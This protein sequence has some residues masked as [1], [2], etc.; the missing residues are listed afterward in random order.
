MSSS[1]ETQTDPD[2]MVKVAPPTQKLI[3]IAP[4][5]LTQEPESFSKQFV[6]DVYD[7]IAPHFSH[8]RYK[9][10]PK[11]E[12]FVSN[13]PQG[14]F[15]MD[16]GCGNGKNLVNVPHVVR[17]GSDRSFPFC[18]IARDKADCEALQADIA[19]DIGKSFRVGIF[20]ATIAIAVIHHIPDVPG[21]IAALREI[22]RLLR[23]GGSALIYVWA[24]EQKK[25]TIGA[26]SF[27]SQDI[28]VPWN[29]QSAYLKPEHGVPEGQ[30]VPLQRYYHVFT[31]EEFRDLLN[32]VPEFEIKDLYYD[33]NNWAA[34]LVASK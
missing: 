9:K 32:Q 10:W 2:N 8:T 31:E 28:F 16:A 30:I 12:E 33:N 29:L 22:H 13:L 25:G 5:L 18:E 21:R 11:V 23:R 19:R 4:K 34:R 3:P 26:R 1:E 24:M 7:K 27:E 17:Y 6:F 14:S 20:D 15:L